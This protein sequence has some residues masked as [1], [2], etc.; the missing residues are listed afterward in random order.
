MRRGDPF[1][2]ARDKMTDRAIFENYFSL[3]RETLEEHGLKN[4]PGQI[5]NCD[6][7]G[8]PLEHTPPKTIAIKGT[9]KVCQITSGNKT[10]ISILACANA[11]GEVIPPMV[12][13]GEKGLILNCQMGKCLEQLVVYDKS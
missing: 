7:S 3:L 13:F 9:K 1:S 5:Y 10:Q 8:M 2:V 6:E 12:I 4:R 11:F